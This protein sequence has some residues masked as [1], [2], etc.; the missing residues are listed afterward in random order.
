MLAKSG[1]VFLKKIYQKC[2]SG[3]QLFSCSALT[4]YFNCDE[5]SLKTELVSLCKRGYIELI[6]TERHGEPYFF[7]TVKP[8]ASEYF[9]Q[10]KSRKTELIIKIVLACL[11]AV[12]TFALGKILY[13]LFS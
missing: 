1:Y 4:E 3:E 6:N 5:Q 9:K 12:I 11:S 13:A 10:R 7:I 2:S 8:K